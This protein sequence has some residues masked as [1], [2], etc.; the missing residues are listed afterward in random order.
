[1]ASTRDQ[2]AKR[3]SA[4]QARAQAAW[5]LT[6]MLKGNG[7]FL[8]C[9]AGNRHQQEGEEGAH[10]VAHCHRVWSRGNYELPVEPGSVIGAILGL[11][12]TELC[13]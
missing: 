10:H 5:M 7:N 3:C 2:N 9:D 11:I 1:M 8:P 4:Q 6:S 12:I 13:E